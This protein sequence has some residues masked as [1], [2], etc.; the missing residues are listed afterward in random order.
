MK[1]PDEIKRGLEVC[2][3]FEGCAA[4]PY[5]DEGMHGCVG[6][7]EDALAY[8]QQLE[9]KVPRW[10][11]VKERLPERGYKV[12]TVNGHGYIR[13]FALWKKTEREWCWI[14]DAGHFNH[15]NDITHW[16]EMPE[17]PEEEA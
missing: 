7:E 15:V 1:T 14:D 4:C 11:G 13:I 6:L 9:A 2:T 10:I 3:G 12:L 5:H 8:I 17:L 16:M